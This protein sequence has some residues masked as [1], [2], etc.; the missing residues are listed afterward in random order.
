MSSHASLLVRFAFPVLSLTAIIGCGGGGGGGAP[1]VGFVATP[2]RGAPPLTVQFSDRTEGGPTAWLWTFGDGATST[3]QNPTHEYLAQSDYSVSLTVTWADGKQA[4]KLGASMIQVGS[5]GPSGCDLGGAWSVASR[6]VPDESCDP[7]QVPTLDDFLLQLTFCQACEAEAGQAA[8][9]YY[10][11]GGTTQGTLGAINFQT[12]VLD[13]L[14]FA[15][16]GD[17]YLAS[18][19]LTFDASIGLF[20]TGST[21]CESFQ[22]LVSCDIY[23]G[24]ALV[25]DGDGGYGIDPEAFLLCTGQM[26]YLGSRVGLYSGRESH[27]GTWQASDGTSRQAVLV[28]D[29]GEVQLSVALDPGTELAAVLVSGRLADDRSFTLDQRGE[30]GSM[31]LFAT[32]RIDEQG[33]GTGFLQ[34]LPPRAGPA[35]QGPLQFTRERGLR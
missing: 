26:E 35:L 28:I 13:P 31:S 16:S 10:G 33:E 17:Y 21:D 18:A 3:E 9:V 24:N 8:D 15:L 32:G 2:T 7:E 25:P 14:R 5:I 11:S 30:P 34:V 29:R 20:D 22:C 19:D 12:P 6:F 23:E 27:L 1:S 4:S